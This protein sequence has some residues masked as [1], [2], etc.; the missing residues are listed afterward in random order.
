[1]KHSGVVAIL[2]VQ[3]IAAHGPAISYEAPN[4]TDALSL[5]PSSRD[6]A[7]YGSLGLWSIISLPTTSRM[8]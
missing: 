5:R 1:M 3:I 7:G 4:A 8:V 6:P 2:I